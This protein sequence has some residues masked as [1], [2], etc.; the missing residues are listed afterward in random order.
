MSQA[1]DHLLNLKSVNGRLWISAV[2]WKMIQ[3]APLTGHGLG[4]FGQLFPELQAEA[5]SHPW[6][7]GFIPNASFTSYAHN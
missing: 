3:D 2:T 6:A 5:F 4:T 7:D 1:V